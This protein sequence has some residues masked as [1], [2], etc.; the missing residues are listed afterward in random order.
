M[1]NIES[2]KSLRSL[3][4]NRPLYI[5]FINCTKRSVEILWI[6]FS[7]V[8]ISYKTLLPYTYYDVDTYFNH[9]WIFRDSKTFDKMVIN[10][11]EVFQLTL[12]DV[13][14][15]NNDP[16]KRKVF[17]IVLPLYTLKEMCFQKV[18]DGLAGCHSNIYKLSIPRTLQDEYI[19]FT[20]SQWR[21]L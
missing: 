2:L 13:P 16:P 17:C 7:G 21:D 3:P 6:N 20:R 19:H 9:A 15:N 1:S 18:R 8:R 5:R 4:S 14:S 10:K 11:N 12:K